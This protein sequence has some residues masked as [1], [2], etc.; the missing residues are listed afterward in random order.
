[1]QQINSSAS[2]VY[3][4]TTP[5]GPRYVRAVSAQAARVRAFVSFG[6]GRTVVGEIGNSAPDNLGAYGYAKAVNTRDV[7]PSKAAHRDKAPAL[8]S[9]FKPQPTIGQR[10]ADNAARMAEVLAM[11]A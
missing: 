7:M 6:A 1:M 9:F 5:H 8:G 3:L 10:I 2:A 4:V 11:F